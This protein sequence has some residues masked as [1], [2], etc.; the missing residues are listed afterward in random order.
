MNLS[1][2]QDN[3][4]H[5]ARSVV[6]ALGRRIYVADGDSR[7]DALV[8]AGGD[9]NPR[10]LELWRA[11]LA[12]RDWDVIVDVGANYGEML[13]G[14]DVPSSAE[15]VV[16][17]PSPLILPYLRRSLGEAG[18]RVD[19]RECAVGARSAQ[20]QE[21]LLDN[22]WSGMSGLRDS[23]R[24][25]LSKDVTSVRVPVTTLSDGLKDL[26]AEVSVCIKVDVEGAEL[27][28]LEGAREFLA[29]RPRWAIMLEILHMDY[30]EI[31]KLASEFRGGLLDRRRAQIVGVPR[32]T[33]EPLRN[34]VDASWT[35]RQDL[36]LMSDAVASERV[37]VPIV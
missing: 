12:L 28:V 31:R 9:F 27:E 11:T 35:Y 26:P 30:V 19:L 21:F 2:E 25:G 6:N 22:A 36:V 15:V 17:E 10:S 7:G 34:W 29:A 3:D 13:L 8:A 33:L 18:M 5:N 4:L 23:H 16:F 37:G 14:I 1:V 20:T 24:S 32:T